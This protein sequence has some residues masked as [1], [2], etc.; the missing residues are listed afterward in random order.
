MESG[1]I[2]S[3]ILNL[4]IKC[5]TSRPESSVNWI[6]SGVGR[7]MAQA[8]TRRHLIAC[9]SMWDLWWTK[10]HLDRFF[11][12]YFGFPGVPLKGKRKKIINHLHHRLRCVRSIC[13]GALHPKK[14]RVGWAA[15]SALN[16]Q[17]YEKFLSLP[18][19]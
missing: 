16:M 1:A 10:W 5:F 11:P 14:K 13:C 15:E 2:S 3:C 8:V 19:T 18:G 4:D 6:K 7:D 9:Q 17:R 12:E